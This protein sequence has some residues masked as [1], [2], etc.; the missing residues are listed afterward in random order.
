M[1][2]NAL[3]QFLAKSIVIVVTGNNDY[4]NNYLMPGYSSSY[5]YSTQQFGNLLVNNLGQQ[6]LVN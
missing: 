2:P 5:N 4:I 1:D 3:N 6:I